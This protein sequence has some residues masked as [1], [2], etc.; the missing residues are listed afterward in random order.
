MVTCV[1]D[2]IGYRELS[3]VMGAEVVDLDLRVPLSAGMFN[4][5][6]ELF[7]KYQFLVFRNQQLS[8]D[9]QVSFCSQFGEIEPHPTGFVPWERREITYVANINFEGELFETCG[10]TFELWHSD[11]CYLNKPAKMS[12]LYA[13]KVPSKYGETLFANMYKA[14]EDLP[15][16]M[17]RKLRGKNAVF[18]SGRKLMER[19]QKK[20]YGLQIDEG[21]MLPDV[22]HPVFRKHPVT[23][24]LSIFVNWA[25]TDEIIGFPKADSDEMLNYIYAH[26]RK[27]E[28]VYVHS[29]TQGDLVVWDNAST[30]HSN[31]VGKLA[32]PRI[33]RR[34]MIRGDVPY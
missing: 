7:Y 1:M 14:Y 3:D 31:C 26:C 5:I 11:T 12:F 32:E 18:G 34:V 4:K 6:L 21:D 24:R 30:L 10:P 28:Y 8:I 27:S 19:C 33:M 13:E 9:E 20:G 2:K 22:V 17:Q 23:H 15:E 25:H 16:E 29:Y